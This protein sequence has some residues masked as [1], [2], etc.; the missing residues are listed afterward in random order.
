MPLEI[1]VAD[2]R[3]RRVPQLQHWMVKAHGL[4]LTKTDAA[5][6]VTVLLADDGAVK[7]L[8]RRWRGKN[9]PTNVLSF[10]A[11]DIKLPRS[12]AK[13]LGDLALAYDTC[14]R[15]AKAQGKSLRAHAVHLVVH[16]L[17]HLVGHDHASDDEANRMEARE[18]RILAKLGIADPYMLSHGH[19]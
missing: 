13:P 17:L 4:C 15:E 9:K 10:P 11:P 5:K 6:S 16:G 18:T 3:W 7:A 14:A 19:D 8:N 1:D 2:K 12:E